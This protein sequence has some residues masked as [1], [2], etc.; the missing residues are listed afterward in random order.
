MTPYAFPAVADNWPTWIDGAVDERLERVRALLG[1]VRAA[2]PE[3]V[4]ELWNELELA[5]GDADALVSTF[6]EVHPD[7][8]VRTRSEEHAQEISRLRTEI[9]LDRTLYDALA[10]TVED[11]LDAHAARVREHVLRDFRRAGVDRPD[12]VRERLRAIAER[13][14]VLDQDFARGIRDDV[15]SVRVRPEQ[16]DGL[17]SDFV[18]AHPVG[19]DGLVEL[20]TD[21]PDLIPVRTFARDAAVRQDLTFAALNRAWPANDAVLKEIL[22]LRHEQAQLL[23]YADWPDYDAEVKMIGNGKA[24]LEFIDQAASDAEDAARRDY[25]VLLE[26]ARQ[27]DPGKASLNAADR[28]YLETLVRHESYQVD[29]Q[30][31]RAY[32]DFPAVRA[33]LLDVTGRLFGIEYRPADVPLWHEDVVAYDVLR[34]GTEVGRIYL[35]L[36]P[37]E[38]KFKHAA[39]FPMRAGIAGRQLPEGALVCNL[40]RGLME[41][42]EVVTLF[43]EFGHLVHEVLAG[44]QRWRQLSG[45]TTEWDFVEAPS[46]LL[47]EWAWDPEVL[48]TFARNADGEAIP[49]D[50]VAAMRAANEFGKGC[51]V[52]TQMFYAALSYVVHRD[53]PDDL[54]ATVRELQKRYDL[55][56]YI[57][58]THFHASFGHLAGYTSGYYT[59]LWSLVIAKD[60]FSAFDPADLFA[61]GVAHRYRD[62]VLARGGSA[63]AADL[64]ADFLG[65]PYSFAAFRDW[66]NRT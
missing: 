18:D 6:A 36:H 42:I 16:L 3:Q 8:A 37:R 62:L 27:D 5:L 49:V 33:G 21:S 34:D 2:G 19:E 60:L 45:I 43:H 26:R 64:V 51:F 57:E 25:A 63:D 44:G 32:F 54:T 53:R 15:R 48:R 12:E 30:R 55:F 35:D 9:S 65:R 47:E 46:Q 28:S 59:Y 11:G 23:G 1:E 31:V 22:D 50:L 17:P 4:L 52:R 24:I 7:E 41:H 39:Q 13:L 20:T 40:P 58:G 29:A 66:L 14:T 61:P 38:G 10:A 56:D